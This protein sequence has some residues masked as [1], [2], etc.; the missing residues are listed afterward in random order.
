[1]KV[2]LINPPEN[3]NLKVNFIS[4][5]YPLNLGYLASVLVKNGFEVELWDYV[6]ENFN[7][8]DFIKRIQKS[9]PDL[10][11]L[12]SMTNTILS[13]AK[14]AHVIKKNFS[15]ILVI[16]G[17]NHVT[18]LPERT[19]NEIPELDMIC[20][21]EGEETLLELCQAIKKEEKNINMIP[22]LVYRHECI[23][24]RNPNR[25]L[26]R[27]IDS[28]PFPLRDLVP[29]ELYRQS[30]A[31][32]GISRKFLNV[33]EL[34]TSRGCPN[35]CIFC[36]GHVSYGYKVRM[37]SAKNVL[38]EAK[39]CIKK[40]GT[41]HFTIQDDT[42]SLVPKRTVEICEGLQQLKVTWDCNTRV[43]NISR[44]LIFKMAE[45]GCQKISFGVE[46]SS[47]RML[48]LIK[49]GITLEQV[50][51]AFKWAHEAKIKL[52]EGTFILG[53]HPSE[54]LNEVKGTLKLMKE[55]DL[56][57]IAYGIIIP[58]PGTEVYRIMLDKGYLKQ[59]VDWGK[60]IFF[61]EV[62]PWRIENFDSA[63]LVK[64]QKMVLRKFHLRP[65]YILK[66]LSKISSF[67]EFKYYC[68]AAKDYFKTIVFGLKNKNFCG[69]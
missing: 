53:A 13:V 34:L 32:R 29:A 64:L 25:E 1:M 18:V 42:F 45:T 67:D 68:G 36:A 2:V 37:R 44:E 19:M 58:F 14:L 49:K 50:R 46:A 12:T 39:E 43:N 59:D 40:Y 10:I 38:T 4:I 54:T 21:G 31:S 63:E 35:Q 27:D 30:H 28:L 22:G 57:F 23:I 56:D 16:A 65:H 9:R 11:G 60:F 48:N 33:A 8:I 26:I 52:I 15:D 17:G 61:G 47:E 62:P 66:R 69:K 20:V 7:E 24:V 5:Q 41:N 3:L 55:L 51:N 6:V